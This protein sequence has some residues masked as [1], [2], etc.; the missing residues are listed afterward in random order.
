MQ[1]NN[2]V[3]LKREIDG[4]LRYLNL[5]RSEIAAIKHPA[6]EK[7]GFNR[8]GDQLDAI[9]NATADA[10]NT[11]MESVEKMISLLTNYEK[12]SKFQSCLTLSMKLG[13]SLVMFMKPV[14]FKISQPNTLVRS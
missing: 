8:M 12:Q 3:V 5:V 1:D 9:V 7:H 4:L 2:D 13:K 10:T 14:P 11:I 6:D